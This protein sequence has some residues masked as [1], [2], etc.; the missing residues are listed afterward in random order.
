MP[1]LTRRRDKDLQT[2]HWLIF[3]D[4]IHIGSIGMRADVPVHAEQ[5]Q[6]TISVYPPSHRGI[7]DD[8]IARSFAEARAAFE[9]A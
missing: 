1:M 4:D 5:W 7:R 8:G 9:R 6:W 3:A 2:D